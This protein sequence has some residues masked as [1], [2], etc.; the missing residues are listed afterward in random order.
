M[1][2]SGFSTKV[3]L[4]ANI[5]NGIMAVFAGWFYMHV[6]ADRSRRRPLLIFGYVGLTLVLL[7]VTICARVMANT[8]VFPYVVVA[9]TM[10]YVLIFDTTSGPLT[11]L[12]LSEIFPLHVRGLG[13]GFSTLFNFGFDF[14]VGL[15]FPILISVI[16]L[17]NSFMVFVFCGI[18]C[19]VASIALVPE[20]LG[21]SLEQ[22]EAQF[23]RE[24]KVQCV[25]SKS[26]VLKNET[27][28][29]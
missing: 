27:L 10:T 8:G 1:E 12:L 29:K 11:W 7:A 5:A 2:T 14:V 13:T 26:N 19:I 18:I 16:G 9:L 21:K 4:I 25:K 6:L 23:R 3:A 28:Q 17:S 15:S 22:L 24:E 20:T